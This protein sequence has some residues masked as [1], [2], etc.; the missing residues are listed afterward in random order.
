[1]SPG[2]VIF[3]RNGT[4]GRHLLPGMHSQLVPV[5]ARGSGRSVIPDEFEKN[6]RPALLLGTPPRNTSRA[7]PGTELLEQ[8]DNFSVVLVIR[9]RL[10]S[11][12]PHVCSSPRKRVHDGVGLDQPEQEFAG[13]VTEL[14]GVVAVW[15]VDRRPASPAGNRRRQL[16]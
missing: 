15:P 11:A 3:I 8:R 6:P 1:M 7:P 16:G 9:Q 5:D 14:H 4:V 13:L 2:V 12:E 10:R